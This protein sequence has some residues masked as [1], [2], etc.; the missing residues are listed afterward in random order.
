MNDSSSPSSKRRRD[1][2]END[3]NRPPPLA[4]LRSP[5]K[6]NGKAATP[7]APRIIIALDIDQFYVAAS[8]MR[9]PSLIG[10]PIGIKQKGILATA[11]YEA[12][13]L[14][15]KKLAAVRDAV[16]KCPDLILVNGED[17]SFFRKLSIRVWRLVRSIVWQGKVEKLGLDEL[18]CD[19]TDM[20]EWNLQRDKDN[21]DLPSKRF[22]RLDM[23]DLAQGFEYEADVPPPGHFLPEGRDVMS[24][25]SSSGEHRRLV[26]ASHLCRYIRQT[27]LD[28]VGLTTSGG[29]AHNKLL[30]KLACSKHK[31]AEQTIFRPSHP[32]DVEC[33]L[34]PYDIRALNGFGGAIVNR[35]RATLG[36]SSVGQWIG[37]TEP[38]ESAAPPL[39]VELTRKAFSLQSF[40]DMFGQRLG[41]RLYALLQ[42]HDDDQVHPAPPFPLQI[43]IEDTYR[44]IKGPEIASQLHVLSTSLL[45]RLEAELVED[46]DFATASHRFEAALQ[47]ITLPAEEGKEPASHLRGVTVRS[48]T[49]K[50]ENTNDQSAKKDFT[51]K[52]YPLS[53]RLSI[54]Q[55]WEN[56]I[57]KQT[58]MPVEI[59]DAA[60]DRSRRAAAMVMTLSS[61]FRAMIQQYGDRGEGINLINIAAL[62][63]STKKPSP[64]LASFFAAAGGSSSKAGASDKETIDINMLREL[65]LELQREVAQQYGL[66]LAALQQELAE[67]SEQETVSV[68]LDPPENLIVDD[69]DL[70]QSGSDQDL[71]CD[72]CGAV[73]QPWL[74][75]DHLLWPVFG[76]PPCFADT[77]G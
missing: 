33:F 55:G 62:D 60:L 34:D 20:I 66:D 76:L 71:V 11:S 4:L 46:D 10:L 7:S 8:R 61:L 21:L 73:Q 6:S 47:P 12:R 19:V 41:S 22:F 43:S 50:E 70:V 27:I 45:R 48:Y 67:S 1:F 14:G 72:K 39:T 65:P 51:W 38:D 24:L 35:L 25:A 77:Q 17:L 40:L 54:R 16:K 29:V 3:H 53:I 64:A 52:R 44:G 30:A 18:F 5:S 23:A 49:E 58:R 15:V 13:A 57:S 9:D 75:H 26:L 59:F 42:G 37:D 2:D 56:R 31:P 69:T 28:Q 74:Q 63:L 36:G 68:A 32:R